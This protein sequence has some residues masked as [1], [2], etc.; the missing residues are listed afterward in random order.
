MDS[1]SKR[2]LIGAAR[3]IFRWSR[4][5]KEALKRASVGTKKWACSVCNEVV[6]PK[7]RDVDH[8]I[9]V[10]DVKALKWSWDAFYD[11][12]FCSADNL[13]VLCKPCHKKKTAAEA[14]IRA[15]ARKVV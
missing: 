14:K 8:I 9:P 3:K 12:L 6:G 15:K 11:R 7:E 4:E 10:N 2:Y 5:R 1:L 13:R